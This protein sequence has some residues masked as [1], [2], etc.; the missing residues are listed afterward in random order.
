[1]GLL[2]GIELVD[3][4]IFDMRPDRKEQ[5]LFAVEMAK[6]VPPA[7]PLSFDISIIKVCRNP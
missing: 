7:T 4:G 5:G 6:I 1:M 2:A 3:N